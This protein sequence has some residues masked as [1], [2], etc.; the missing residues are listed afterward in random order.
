MKKF[1]A[2]TLSVLL[3][4]LAATGC[5]QASD[6]TADSTAQAA[7]N[8]TEAPTAQPTQAGNLSTAYTAYMEIKSD[9]IT[10]LADGLTDS[11]PMASMEL[12]GMNM[13]ELFLV[14]MAAMGMDE[15]YAQA[16]LAYM[17]A[18]NV[19]YTAD[20]NHYTLTYSDGQG[21]QMVCDS[22]Y[23]PAKDSAVTKITESEKDS[24][25]FEYLK[26]SYGYASQY[27]LKNDDGTYTVY[28]GTFYGKD[29]VIGVTDKAVAQPESIVGNGEVPENFPKEC[30]NWFEAKGTAGTGMLSNGTALE[31]TVPAEASN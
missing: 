29:G 3:I 10:R 30:D 16:T 4:C 9:L 24:L 6:T 20:G 22:T 13:V 23:D 2:M 7:N 25:V 17:S 1:I 27:Y 8:S 19:K 18:S 5:G 28:K 12:L 31:F 26:T 21:N 14:P 11:Q 15:T